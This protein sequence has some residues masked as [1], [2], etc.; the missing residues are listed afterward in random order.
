MRK[1]GWAAVAPSLAQRIVSGYKA[2][3][4]PVA[5]GGSSMFTP[6]RSQTLT[7]RPQLEG[8]TP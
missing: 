4:S 3:V 8:L 6:Q 1:L 7:S 5:A 2:T